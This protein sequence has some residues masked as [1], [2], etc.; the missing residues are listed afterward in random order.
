LI[1]Q[2]EEKE[3]ISVCQDGCGFHSEDVVKSSLWG[4]KDQLMLPCDQATGCLFHGGNNEQVGPLVFWEAHS[5]ILWQVR[6]FHT[7]SSLA[8]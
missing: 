7:L 1:Q 3:A 8:G 2:N 4:P 6:A 5:A